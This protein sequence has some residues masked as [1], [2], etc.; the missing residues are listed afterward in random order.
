[1][2]LTTEVTRLVFSS[3]VSSVLQEY[4]LKLW[5]FHENMFIYFMFIAQFNATEKQESD[6]KNSFKRL[7]CTSIQI[8][9]NQQTIELAKN[10][11][12]LFFLIKILSQLFISKQWKRKKARVKKS[13]KI[14]D[15]LSRLLFNFWGQDRVKRS[16]APISYTSPGQ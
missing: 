12:N 4:R 6:R 8:K 13:F 9:S 11:I 14:R 7:Y 3:L 16:Q 1:M 2:L 15:C 5:R 10:H